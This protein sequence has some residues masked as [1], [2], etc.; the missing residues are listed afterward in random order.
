MNLRRILTLT[1]T[2]LVLA[3]PAWARVVS[4]RAAV[5]LGD[6]SD[7]SIDRAIKG[8]VD[9]CVR[10]ATA[11]GLSWIWLQDAAVVGDKIL[12]QMVASDDASDE[13]DDL[14]IVDV[15]PNVPR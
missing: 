4:F 11:M 6:Q 8:A 5:P 12:I 3:S 1:L 10:E 2:L 13:A 7:P 9:R 15:T 14:T